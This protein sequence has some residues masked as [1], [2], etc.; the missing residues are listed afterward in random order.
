MSV[1]AFANLPIVTN[2]I[3]KPIEERGQE[4]KAI[5]KDDIKH[6]LIFTG[7]LGYEGKLFDEYPHS[8][9]YPVGYLYRNNIITSEPAIVEISKFFISDDVEEVFLFRKHL[10]NYYE[11]LDIY[12]PWH[13]PF[14]DKLVDE[15]ATP[16]K[17]SGP[18]SPSGLRVGESRWVVY[19]DKREIVFGPLIKN[20]C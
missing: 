18:H 9:K 16:R 14:Y 15:G 3:L 12:P 20:N 5:P 6:R 13:S 2:S 4:L 17:L 11:S 19:D 10:N 8:L 1:L 7:F